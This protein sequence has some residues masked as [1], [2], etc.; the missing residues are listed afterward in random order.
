MSVPTPRQPPTS[1]PQIITEDASCVNVAPENTHGWQG[2]PESLRQLPIKQQDT[3]CTPHIRFA[4]DEMEVT[5]GTTQQQNRLDTCNRGQATV[6]FSTIRTAAPDPSS[7]NADGTTQCPHLS[8]RVHDECDVGTLLRM[9]TFY[10]R[11]DFH[12]RR[13]VP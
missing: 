1:P 13:Y 3:S 9:A 11:Y 5:T 2:D 12:I 4:R 10:T 8:T 6:S 7:D